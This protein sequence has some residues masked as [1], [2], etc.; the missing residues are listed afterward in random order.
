[1]GGKLREEKEGRGVEGG[2]ER[3]RGEEEEGRGWSVRWESV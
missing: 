3:R 2:R 1:M